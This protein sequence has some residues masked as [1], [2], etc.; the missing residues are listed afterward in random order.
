MASDLKKKKSTWN[1][2]SSKN[3]YIPS[4]YKDTGQPPNVFQ[5]TNHYAH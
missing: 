5:G 2:Q 3:T 1:P 4:P